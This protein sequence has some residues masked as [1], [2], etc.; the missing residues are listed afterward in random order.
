MYNS[1]PATIGTGGELRFS[2]GNNLHLLSTAASFDSY[3]HS[4][5]ANRSD[6][7]LPRRKQI[8]IPQASGPAPEPA[9]VDFLA[10]AFDNDLADFIEGYAPLGWEGWEI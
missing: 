8:A 10:S 3:R 4:Q 7:Y 9:E 1:L 2:N 6:V 5:F